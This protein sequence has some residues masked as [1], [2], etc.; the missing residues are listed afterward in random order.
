MTRIP[1][2]LAAA[3][4]AACSTMPTPTERRAAADQL[5][6]A[7][8]WEIRYID[9][10]RF[11]LAAW[12]PAPMPNNV[13][14]TIYIEGDGFAWASPSQ[15]AIDPTPLDPI[16]LKLALAQ[17]NGNVAYLARPCQFIDAEAT[18]CAVAYWTDR[19]FSE[20]V[21]AATDRA[22]GVLKQEAGATD[23]TLVGY[24]GGG[25]IAALVAARRNDVDR[26]VTVAGN[27]DHSAWTAQHR[28]QPLEGSLNPVDEVAALQRVRQWHFVGAQDTIVPPDLVTAFVAR[29]PPG[30]R[31][32][33][34]IEPLFD[35]RCCWAAQWSSLW[36]RLD[37]DR[38]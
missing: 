38:P 24:S 8:N 3:V 5:A 32:T 29:F 1:L 19:R 12:R 13:R 10:G 14:L 35:H 30:R 6:R 16:A 34:I 7:K 37:F 25:A 11:R 2:L 28:V 36:P 20:E 4:L 31:P 9:A 21:V 18:H 22:I 33:V 27:L 26:L 17:P 15:P 23:L